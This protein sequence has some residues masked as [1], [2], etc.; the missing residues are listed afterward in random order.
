MAWALRTRA[1][2]AMACGKREREWLTGPLCEQRAVAR[3]RGWDMGGEAVA[4]RTS[5]QRGRASRR[6]WAWCHLD[7]ALYLLRSQ[8]RKHK[9]K[10]PS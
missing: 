4:Q 8:T 6:G 2:R 10:E 3:V 9:T 1:L 5:L 7:V